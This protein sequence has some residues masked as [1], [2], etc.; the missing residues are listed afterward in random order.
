M[1]YIR[2]SDQADITENTAKLSSNSTAVRKKAAGNLARNNPSNQ[3]AIRVAQGIVPLVALLSHTRTWGSIV[4]AGALWDLAENNPDNQSVMLDNNA[5][6]L[7][8]ELADTNH[9][10]KKAL[11]ACQSCLDDQN[12][13]E[14]HP[15]K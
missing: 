10:A 15:L 2:G 7:L 11:E 3:D 9:E 4:A 14:L 1:F 12:S 13:Q 8:R 6:P 5:L